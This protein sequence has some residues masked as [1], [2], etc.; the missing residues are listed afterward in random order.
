MFQNTYQGTIS[1]E[2]SEI[3]IASEEFERA[4]YSNE[5]EALTPVKKLLPVK[6]ES[7][8]ELSK[9]IQN[10]IKKL[11]LEFYLE[12]LKTLAIQQNIPINSAWV[13]LNVAVWDIL[14][15]EDQQP[16]ILMA[17]NSLNSDITMI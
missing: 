15:L 4:S 16:Y 8:S 2:R 13:K 11:A 17:Q 3:V 6:I 7:N 10:E 1:N 12:Q 9:Q 5:I 14:L